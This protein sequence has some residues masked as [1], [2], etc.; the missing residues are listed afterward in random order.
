MNIDDIIIC[1]S[2]RTKTTGYNLIIGDKYQVIGAF[3]PDII[4]VINV[5]TGKTHYWIPICLF[6][7]VDAFRDSKIE[8]I[9]K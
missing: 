6:D 8:D 7:K 9:L 5:K 1:V 3:S 4:D 2:I